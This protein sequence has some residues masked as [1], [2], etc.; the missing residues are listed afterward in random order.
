MGPTCHGSS[1][2]SA[3]GS[4]MMAWHC[5]INRKW[6][7]K[8][9]TLVKMALNLPR[10]LVGLRYVS[11]PYQ[12]KRIPQNC[13][14]SKY[15]RTCHVSMW[16]PHMVTWHYHVNW[17]WVLQYCHVS[18]VG[19]HAMSVVPHLHVSPNMPRHQFLCQWFCKCNTTFPSFAMFNTI[20]ELQDT[21]FT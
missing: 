7:H 11:L 13:L 20:I 19:Q 16:V 14:L 2:I 12:Q 4:H 3:S 17:R 9:V 10:Q 8:T 15:G 5:H 6:S 18:K 1:T 21:F